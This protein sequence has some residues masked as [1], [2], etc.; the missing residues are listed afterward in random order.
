MM[1]DDVI[2]LI[3][4]TP[5][6]HGVLEEAVRTERGVFC[7]IRSVGYNEFYQAKAAGLNP[8]LVF[9][10]MH[11]FEYQG[12]PLCRY[13]GTVYRII[14]TYVTEADGIELTVERSWPDA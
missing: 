9:M 10:L 4:E 5:G 6:T 1:R 11:D 13:H 8:E 2:T 14:R 12:E 7:R 3:S